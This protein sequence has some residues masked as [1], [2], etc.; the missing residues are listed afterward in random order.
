MFLKFLKISS[1]G[2]HFYKVG[3][4]PAILNLFFRTPLNDLTLIEFIFV[5]WNFKINF[6]HKSLLIVMGSNTILKI[7]IIY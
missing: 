6:E 7:S 4:E 5:K 3:K 1:E 2:C